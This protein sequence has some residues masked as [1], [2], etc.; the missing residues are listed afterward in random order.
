M[1][2][3]VLLATL[4]LA[5]H[6][7]ETAMAAAPEEKPRDLNTHHLFT[8]PNDKAV[9]ETRRAELRRQVLFSAGLWPMP[10]KTP[11]N[12]KITGKIVAEDYT[13]ENVALETRPGF[14]LCG[15]LYRPKGKKGPHPGIVNPHGHWTHGRLEMQEDVPKADPSGA[16][17]LGRG[18]LVSIGVN[19]AR[20]GFVVFAYDAVGYNDTNQVDHEF[21]KSL[22][23][24]SYGVSELGLQLW[25]SIR[26]VDYLQSLRDVDKNRIGCTGASGGGSQTF[27]LTAVDDRVKAA[28]PVNMVS[29]YMQGGCLCENGPGLRVGT[30]NVEIAA[31]TAPRPM[32]MVACTGDWTA[33]N[34]KE[35]WPAVK[36]IYDL[37]GAGD[38]TAVVQFNYQ[39]NYN[40]ESRE[41]M[42][43]WFGKY[44]LNDPDASHFR[45]KPFTADVSKMHAWTG[46]EPKP[47]TA[48]EEPALTDALIQ[49]GIVGRALLMP[50]N[51]SQVK[52]F[53]ATYLAGLKASLGADFPSML[54]RRRGSGKERVLLVVG[55]IGDEEKAN[56]IAPPGKT[57]Y[58]S[59]RR[60]M[61][62]PVT[63]TEAQLWQN[64]YSTYNRTPLGDR[65]HEVVKE[66]GAI[67]ANG[68]PTLDVVGIGEAGPWVLFARAL[69]PTSPGARTVVDWT[70]IKSHTEDD[71]YV[72]RLYAPGLRRVGDLQTAILLSMPSSLCIHNLGEVEEDNRTVWTSTGVTA[73]DLGGNLKIE[74]GPL[75]A[76]D[77]TN[78]LAK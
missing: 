33:N 78:W 27:L 24:W 42:Y 3:R 59:I 14:F 10:E 29:A 50:Y 22:R 7:T 30:D 47:K 36:K 72:N 35:E 38:K 77:I 32:L 53:R 48:L 58:T 25:D 1:K 60:V 26:V 34:P 21:A 18:N 63:M 5:A 31:I 43:A 2:T 74:K 61:L 71:V 23:A 19:L 40:I 45:E 37:Y 4:L 76:A 69:S 51:R 6:A 70:Q 44:L 16:M 55:V 57:R 67:L 8:P 54:N 13:I 56:A 39:H 68:E 17:G 52:Q 75:T 11:L 20:Q 15:N 66:I 12:A 41:A 64:Y 62:P 9:W 49:D 65:V 28:V 46:K 73:I